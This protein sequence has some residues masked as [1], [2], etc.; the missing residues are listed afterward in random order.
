MPSR[1]FQRTSRS[2]RVLR[3]RLANRSRCTR[4][5]RLPPQ[6]TA[7]LLPISFLRTSPARSTNL[8]LA[9]PHR[10][11]PRRLLEPWC[12]RQE[13]L[14]RSLRPQHHPPPTPRREP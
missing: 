11:P 5:L 8:V 9:N 4:T 1:S 13:R 3:R 14:L 6:S 12:P 10:R 7:A 2:L